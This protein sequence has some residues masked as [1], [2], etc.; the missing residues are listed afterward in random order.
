MLG[1]MLTVLLVLVYLIIT[2]ALGYRYYYSMSHMK[3][4][5]LRMV[6]PFALYKIEGFSTLT[7]LTCQTGQSH[8]VGDGPV[9]SRMFTSILVLYPLDASGNYD[10]PRCVQALLNVPAGGRR[11]KVSPG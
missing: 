8:V 10:N 7:L 2:T 11:D 1:I 4:L 6:K 3:K 9:H 5:K